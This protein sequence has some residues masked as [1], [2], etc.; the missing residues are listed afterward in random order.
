LSLT[1]AK[2]YIFL[3][4]KSRYRCMTLEGSDYMLKTDQSE[5]I[6]I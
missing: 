5:R 1:S 6:T 3:A 4:Q 2:S